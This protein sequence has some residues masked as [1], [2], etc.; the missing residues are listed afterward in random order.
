MLGKRFLHCLRS[1]TMTTG[2][3]VMALFFVFI[4]CLSTQSFWSIAKTEPA[5]DLSIDTIAPLENPLV[6][7]AETKNGY[8][9]LQQESYINQLGQVFQQ[10]VTERQINSKKVMIDENSE[11]DNF[12]DYLVEKAKNN[13]GY[14]N[15]EMMIAADF[16][17]TE[18]PAKVIVEGLFNAQALHTASTILNYIGTTLLQVFT[19]L[20][21]TLS[22]INHPLPLPGNVED[23]NALQRAQVGGGKI[24]CLYTFFGLCFV[25]ASFA[26]FLVKESSCRVCLFFNVLLK[27]RMKNAFCM[28]HVHQLIL[29]RF[30]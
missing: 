15:N 7:F 11:F 20:D 13:V 21:S 8:E 26:F 9:S 6:V 27:T 10:V 30:F 12:T 22:T 4:A 28:F 2:Q 18:G 5:L 17:A 19:N 29:C 3:V 16:K 25:I 23:A 14:Y 1:P 24:L